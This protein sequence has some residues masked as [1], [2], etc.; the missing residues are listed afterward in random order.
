MKKK[1]DDIMN[2]I[3]TLYQ[4]NTLSA[5]TRAELLDTLYKV[6]DELEY[7]CKKVSNTIDYLQKT[8]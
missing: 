4:L 8:L 5:K 7:K 1:E 2:M 6:E 3:L